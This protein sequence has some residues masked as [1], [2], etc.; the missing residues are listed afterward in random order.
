MGGCRE[1]GGHGTPCRRRPLAREI[2][3]HV[4]AGI[5]ATGKLALGRERALFEQT[6]DVLAVRRR[7]ACYPACHGP[8]V[9]RVLLTC[10]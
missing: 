2:F 5:G 7:A 10:A 6:Q 9:R 8:S 4:V 1:I 3:E